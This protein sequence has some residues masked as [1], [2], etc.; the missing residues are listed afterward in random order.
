M[1]VTW[2]GRK[3]GAA[4]CFRRD[5]RRVK[6]EETGCGLLALDVR[7]SSLSLPY[8]NSGTVRRGCRFDALADQLL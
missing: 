8:R 3:R 5:A 2:N 7:D 6:N 1:G 4:R